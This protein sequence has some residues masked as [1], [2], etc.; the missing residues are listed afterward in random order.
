M[1]LGDIS[2]DFCK[3]VLPVRGRAR[4]H[5][6]VAMGEKDRTFENENELMMYWFLF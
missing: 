3:L 5:G 1:G 2:R 4:T 6:S